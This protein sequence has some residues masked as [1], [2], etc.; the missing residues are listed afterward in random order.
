MFKITQKLLMTFRLTIIETRAR[1]RA[2]KDL[3]NCFKE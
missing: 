3:D 2:H 1:K